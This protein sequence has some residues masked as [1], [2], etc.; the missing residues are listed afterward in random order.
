MGQW[1]FGCQGKP[2]RIRF[3]TCIIN[4]AAAEVIQALLGTPT[5]Q[6]RAVLGKLL[7][8]WSGQGAVGAICAGGGA[9]HGQSPVLVCSAGM[10]QRRYC[11]ADTKT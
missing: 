3:L 6:D 2:Q 11:W 9:L 8:C 1:F 5:S 4:T 10:P 7:G